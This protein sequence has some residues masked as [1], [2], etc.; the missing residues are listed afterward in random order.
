EINGVSRPEYFKKT[1][2]YKKI[3]SLIDQYGREQIAYATQSIFEQEGENFFRYLVKK[4]K[5]RNVTVAGGLFLNVK[6]NTRLLKKKIV[7]NLFVYPNPGDGGVAI[8]AAIA[9]YKRLGFERKIEEMRS[10][11]LGC[12]FDDKEIL[13]SIKSF[14]RKIKFIKLKNSLPKIVAK[15]INQG[16]VLGWFQGRV[17]WGPRA[18]G[19][20]SVLAD[21]RFL[22]TKDRINSKL[23]QRDWFMPFAPAILEEHAKDILVHGFGTPF[24]TLTDDVKPLFSKKIPAA[25]HIDD[26]ARSQIVS[27]KTNQLYWRV[28]YEFYKITGIPV[29][30]NTS[31]NKHGLPV[32]HSPKEAIE[33]LLW[34]CVDK[35]VIGHYL[36]VRK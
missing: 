26:T 13:K 34:G 16:T 23:K 25:V 2:T 1:K 10:T 18:L 3:K 8:G 19:G 15:E 24:M 7:D 33:H 27:K 36:V 11:A 30:L 20:R 9:L 31:F 22:K 6:F 32:V 29:I 4:Y 28:I 21:P 12:E 14:D 17:E 35:L 5:Q